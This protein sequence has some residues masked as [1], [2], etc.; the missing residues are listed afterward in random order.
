MNFLY[1]YLITVF[2]IY[3]VTHSVLMAISVLSVRPNEPAI[4]TNV[5]VD[6]WVGQQWRQKAATFPAL[7]HQLLDDNTTLATGEIYAIRTCSL[8]PI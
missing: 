3:S 8:L 7:P 2:S 5:F 1:Q 4:D 6:W